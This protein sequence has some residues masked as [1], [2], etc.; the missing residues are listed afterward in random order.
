MGF[1]EGC[2]GSPVVYG[3]VG[4]WGG[5]IESGWGGGTSLPTV[6]MISVVFLK[7]CMNFT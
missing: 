3:T 7:V 2:R 5:S 4:E 6:Y 1:G